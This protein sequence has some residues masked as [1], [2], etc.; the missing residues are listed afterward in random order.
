LKKTQGADPSS[1]VRIKLFRGTVRSMNAVGSE[2]A[3]NQFSFAGV[4]S[5]A[6]TLERMRLATLGLR[7]I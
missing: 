4:T 7:F 6:K 3:Q 5:P 2:R 1:T